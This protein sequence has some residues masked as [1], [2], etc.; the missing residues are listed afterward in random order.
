MPKTVTILWNNPAA[1][2]S[3]TALDESQLC[4]EARDA[5]GAAIAG[6]FDYEPEQGAVL[7]P[8]PHELRATFHP[9]DPAAYENATATVSI[10]VLAPVC[11]EGEVK[12]GRSPLDGV[13]VTLTDLSVTPNGNTTCYTTKDQGRY[14]FGNINPGHNVSIEFPPS[15][16]FSGQNVA[17]QDPQLIYC[18]PCEDICLPPTRYVSKGCQISGLVQQADCRPVSG[19]TVTLRPRNDSDV[20]GT[21]TTTDPDGRFCIFTEKTGLLTVGFEDYEVDGNILFPSVDAVDV[22]LAPS[23]P[24]DVCIPAV[25]YSSG[26]GQLCG[27]VTDGKQDLKGVPIDLLDAAGKC[28]LKSHTTDDNGLWTFPNLLPGRYQVRFPGQIPD[29]GDAPSFVEMVSGRCHRCY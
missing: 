23:C 22:F 16:T 19:A 10:S 20:A 13:L 27:V 2:V 5:A 25:T 9:A 6:T 8:G 4:A 26:T 21:Q 17:L 7:P 12:F 11:I 24:S 15:V 28:V 18:R 3:G 14:K 1:I 29:K